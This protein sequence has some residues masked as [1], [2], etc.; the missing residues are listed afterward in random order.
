MLE[1]SHHS[2][3]PSRPGPSCQ[4]RSWVWDCVAEGPRRR[5]L[6]GSPGAAWTVCPCSRASEHSDTGSSG[7]VLA[8]AQA[9]SPCRTPCHVR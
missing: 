2:D 6:F 1:R 7:R 4:K 8:L 3:C 5:H 9:L